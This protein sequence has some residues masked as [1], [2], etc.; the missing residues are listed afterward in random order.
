[1]KLLRPASF[2]CLA[3]ATGCGSET[4]APADAT[5]RDTSSPRDAA[6]VTVTTDA[7]DVAP[8]RDVTDTGRVTLDASLPPPQCSPLR[9]DPASLR[10]ATSGAGYFRAVGGSERGALFMP[11]PGAMTGGATVTIGGGVIGGSQAASFDVIAADMM[12][13]MT[14][15][16]HV[17]VIGP[18][19]VEPAVVRVAPGRTLRFSARGSLGTVRWEILMGP[20]GADGRL[21]AMGVFST[22]TIP[23]VY[24]IRAADP[25]SG[26][27]VQI[28][29]TVAS[30]VTFSPSAAVVL[31]PQGRRVRLDWRGGSG[32]VDAT[33]SAGAVG[34][35]ITTNGDEVTFDATGARPGAVT[36]TGTDR[37]TNERTNLRV[38][39]GEELGPP[40]IPRGLASL[41]GDVAIGDVNGDGRQ[42]LLVG[43]SSRSFTGIETGALLVYLGRADGTFDASPSQA[44]E[45]ERDLDRY[46]AFVQ[47]MDLDNDRIDDVVVASPEQDIG[48][49]GRGAVTFYLGSRAGLVR[50]PERVFVGEN[51]NNRFGTSV[52]LADL[53]G[54]MTKDLIVSA[55]NATNPFMTATC[56]GAGRVY[57]YQ[58]MAGTRGLFVTVPWQVIE[59]KDRLDD[60]DGIPQCRA[61]SDVGRAMA[62]FDI[63][64]DRLLDLI[65]GAPGTQTGNTGSVL[66]YRGGMGGAFEATPAWTLKL[67]TALRTGNPRFGFGLDVVPTAQGQALVVR[68]P[69]FALDSMNRA[70]NQPGGFFVFRQGSLGARPPSGQMRVV[71]TAVASAR[72]IGAADDGAGRSGAVVD[73]DG[74]G[75]LDYVVGGASDRTQDGALHVFE[76]SALAGTGFVTPSV[77]LRGAMREFAGARIAVGRAA[78]GMMA[79]VAVLSAYRNTS[80]ALA[81]GAVRWLAGGA[82]QTP[83]DRWANGA[84]LDLPSFAAGDRTGANLVIA[85]IRTAN[86]G[87]LVV[88]TPGA[89]SPAVPA[90]GT[91]A[92]VPA[93]TTTRVGAVD[94]FRSGEMYSAQRFWVNRANAALGS[95]LAVLDFNGDGRRDVAVG[96]PGAS[97]GGTDMIALANPRLPNLATDPCWLRNNTT[98]ATTSVGGRGLVRVYLQ[99]IDGTFAERFWAIPRETIPPS[100]G[101][102]RRAGFGSVIQNAGDVNGDGFEDLLVGRT[103]GTGNNGAE[104]VLGVPVDTMGRV[105][106]VCNDPAVA[107]M[108]ASRTD[109]TVFGVFV[110][111]V[112]DLDNDG[113]ADTAASI[114]GNTRA[115]LSVQYGFG[116]A[117]R[118]NHR[119]P[120]EMLVVPDDRPVRANAPDP[121]PS[122]QRVSD[123]VDLPGAATGM[124]LVIAGG[125]DVTGDR[126]PD[127]V[128]RDGNLSYRDRVGP[129][130]EILSGAY[131][132]GLCPNRTCPTGVTDNFYSD[133]LGYNVVGLRTLGPPHRLIVPVYNATSVRFGASIAVT[134]VDGDGTG[135]LLVG[136]PDDATQGTF[137]GALLGWR[138]SNDPESFL[139]PPW[140]IAVGDVNE[141]SLF[142]SATAASRDSQGAWIAVGAPSSFHRG[143]QTGAA[144]R[145]RIDR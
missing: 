100:P 24:R 12:C 109:A 67:E 61:A 48:R 36:V 10:I 8:P 119:T 34:G 32:F 47:V 118:N 102:A 128:F 115:G 111:P 89:H 106:V 53:D 125:E 122:A 99:N 117:C 3:L 31:V 73:F 33:I 116:M 112:G 123:W 144:Y 72:F 104:V 90:M 93:G 101:T 37:Y 85:S 136:A 98:V 91:T 46:G 96:D 81:V 95:S 26:N 27:E 2:V 108:W 139:A 63:D 11:A 127:V 23:G 141:Q 21:D 82:R 66:V 57:V 110:A 55:P 132:Q 14:A 113:C 130:V 135:E 105:M 50:P 1:M 78:T 71:T 121:R 133:G 44:F 126:V 5:V 60:M 7:P 137:S 134:D 35:R 41:N 129:A 80:S 86:S 16:G 145:W 4:P 30:G 76:A 124:G 19:V 107:P 140:L 25:G 138:A 49:D 51:S 42:D 13:N 59:M 87:E 20:T 88:G 142:G 84:V 28:T 6:D 22:G 94:V 58:G 143:A 131:L 45:G 75:D 65:V 69:T 62:L 38:V 92:A 40:P 52:I 17:D 54:D 9:L 43:Q 68:V 120:F 70:I 56:N 29:V 18:F 97:S 77:T 79:P 114:S 64:N 39:I 103:G 83:V 15:R 74:D